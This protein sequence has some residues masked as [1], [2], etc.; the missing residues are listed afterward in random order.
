MAG[1]HSHKREPSS[2]N[3][4]RRPPRK[5]SICRCHCPFASK[6]LAALIENADGFV[7]HMV[8]LGKH[9]ES[10]CGED[11]PQLTACSSKPK[12]SPFGALWLRLSF[13]H[14]FLIFFLTEPPRAPHLWIMLAIN[15]ARDLLSCKT[16]FALGS[17]SS[18]GLS[19]APSSAKREKT[20]NETLCECELWKGSGFGICTPDPC[21]RMKS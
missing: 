15:K 21:D 14:W 9:R 1:R 10:V 18:Q 3:K 20:K 4:G 7:L 16:S 5:P 19:T 8:T 12:G 11:K 13:D 2:G 17:N 6:V